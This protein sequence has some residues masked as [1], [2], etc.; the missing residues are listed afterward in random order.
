MLERGHA[1]REIPK[2]GRRT[3]EDE[4]NKV[5]QSDSIDIRHS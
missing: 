4:E 3:R 5:Q 1:E 2:V